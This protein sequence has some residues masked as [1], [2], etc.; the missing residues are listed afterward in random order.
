MPL[1]RSGYLYVKGYPNLTPLMDYVRLLS[2]EGSRQSARSESDTVVAC[3]W[4]VIVSNSQFSR[5]WSLPSNRGQSALFPTNFSLI[6]YNKARA[7][8]TAA[9]L[10]DRLCRAAAYTVSSQLV[11][12]LKQDDRDKLD[13]YVSVHW[14]YAY[15]TPSLKWHS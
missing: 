13:Q 15:S 14:F 8:L 6:L 5:N 12:A 10:R 7:G 3:V 4:Q 2:I 9:I 11:M 1:T